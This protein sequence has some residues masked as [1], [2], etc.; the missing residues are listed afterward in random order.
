M[1]AVT[2]TEFAVKIRVS[3]TVI[4]MAVLCSVSKLSHIS[5]EQPNENLSSE[6][7]DHRPAEHEK[8]SLEILG[9]ATIGV[10]LSME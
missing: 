7:C 4:I 8:L 9:I 3:S 6:I 2:R 5:N 10:I 1:L